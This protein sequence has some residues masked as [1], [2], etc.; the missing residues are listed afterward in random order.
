MQDFETKYVLPNSHALKVKSWLESSFPQDAEFPE[1]IVSSIYFDTYNMDLL[2]EKINSDHVKS[3][4]RIRWYE[5]P[6]T[7]VKSDVCFFEFKHK[8]GERRFK[9]RIKHKNVYG[10]MA[11]ESFSDFSAFNE[12]R[13]HDGILQRHIFPSFIVS[14]TR[15]RFIVPKTNL[16]I[17]I[18]Y[19]I[20]CPKTNMLLVR[21][22]PRNLFLN[23]CVFELKGETAILPK[24]LYEIERMGGRKNSFSKY[25]RCYS[26][27]IDL[28]E[29]GNLW[30]L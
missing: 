10:E 4:Y 9:R 1:A 27:L 17:C 20:N 2:H 18:D 15:K 5:D 3:K 28:R 25:E 19:N 30:T 6:V 7:R 13:L 21:K 23:N 11:L 16:R 26:E 24:E 14:Y 8:V 12:L 22:R 29:Q